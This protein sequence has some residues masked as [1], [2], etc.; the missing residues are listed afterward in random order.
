MVEFDALVIVWCALALTCGGLIK[1]T[2]GVGTPLLTVPLMALVIPPQLAVTIMAIPVV[3]ANFW[4]ASRSARPQA[5]VRR[6][7]P[8]FAAILI[9]TYIGVAVLANIDERLLMGS[10]GF[11]VILFALLQG[12]SWRFQLPA[13]LEKPAG[14]GFGFAS[15]VIGGMSSM[16]GPML[17]IYLV[18]VPGS[19]QGWIRWLHQLPVS[20]RGGAVDAD[21]DPVRS[22]GLGDG[23][24]LCRGDGAGNAGDGGGATAPGQDQRGPVPAAGTGHPVRLRWAP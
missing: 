15:G 9:G 18:S 7:W 4:Q 11:I 1:G 22:A 13:P 16:F 21:T 14:V 23:A 12:S 5:T 3:V 20:R 17:I 6:F 2:L 8:A 24:L 10:V 19:G